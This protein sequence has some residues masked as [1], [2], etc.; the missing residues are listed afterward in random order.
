M[1]IFTDGHRVSDET[2]ETIKNSIN[3]EVNE[4]DVSILE[5]YHNK[6]TCQVQCI[7][8]APNED[9]VLN[10]H[11]KLGIECDYVH[12]LER[13]HTKNTA[14]TERLAAIGELA[15]RL[16]H[17]LRNPLSVIKNTVEIMETK[18]KLRIEDKVIYYSRLHR[19]VD[20]ISHQIED[21]LDFVRPFSLTFE[22]R[23]LNEIIASAM[24]KIT[25]PDSV[26]VTMPQNFVYLV[27]DPIKLE[28]VFTNLI[29][30]AIQAMNNIGQ[31]DIKIIDGSDFVTVQI[32]DTGCGI[33][34][35]VLPRI[36][37]P[38]FTTKQTGTGLGLASCKKIIEQHDGTIKVSSTE[39]V[40]T[41]FRLYLPKRQLSVQ[42][43]LIA[44][45]N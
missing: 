32:T 26:K 28:V 5:L 22:N 40:G 15:A 35:N 44:S 11:K 38:L 23:L 45:Q 24:E 13:I 21:V 27:C 39:G 14:N 3:N 33:P 19:A 16:A 42:N 30:N 34:E 7:M 4:F 37:E 8:E 6:K 17:D 2:L 10:Y 1:P 41:T 25:L 29:M 31:I 36:F 12:Q 18:P 9:A 20:R 43:D